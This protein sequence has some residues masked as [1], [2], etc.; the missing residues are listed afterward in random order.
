MDES[1]T[2]WD[3]PREASLEVHLLGVVDFDACLY[4]QERLVAEIA[5]RNDGR[6]AMLVC[7]HPP[8]LTI[9]REGSRSHITCPPEELTARQM[10]VRWL[11]RGGGCV[12]HVPGQL[13]V[14]PIL[15]LGRRQMGLAALR[16]RIEEA[17]GDMCREF[18]IDTWCKP[19]SA[20]V[21]SRGGQIAQ[22]GLAVHSG[23]SMQGLFVNVSPRMDFL[24]LVR[25]EQG[26]ITSLS[27]ERRIPTAMPAV[28][29]SLIRHLAARLN[30]E[31]YHLYTGHPL[32]RRTRRMVAY[33]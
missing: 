28:R 12:V 3:L 20:G 5:G 33:A 23:V 15:P 7:E 25:S 22:I 26:R 14:Y 30:Y 16:D 31:R 29:E 1:A 32:L 8:L 9:G 4:L 27:A 18:R 17:V 24:R 11:G 21:W 10:E 19:E 6:G 13:A 2:I